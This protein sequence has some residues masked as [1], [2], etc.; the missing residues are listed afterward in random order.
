[1]GHGYLCIRVSAHT[2]CGRRAGRRGRMGRGSRTSTRRAAARITACVLL[3]LAAIVPS[4]AAT[5]AARSRGGKAHHRRGAPRHDRNA[6]LRTALNVAL[7]GT[8]TALTEAAGS[9]AVNAI[10]GDAS[11]QWCST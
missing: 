2:P 4:I 3:A 10:D 9:P 8:V 7:T 11:T 1:V 5:A 6:S